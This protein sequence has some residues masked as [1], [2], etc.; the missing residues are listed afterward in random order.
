MSTVAANM[1]IGQRIEPFL[2]YSLES[3]KFLDEYVVVN[4]GNDDNPNLKVVREIIPSAKIVK[5]E[6]DFNFSKARN[7]ALDNTESQWIIWIDADETHFEAFESLVREYSNSHY[8][9]VVF[10]FYHFIL[11]MFH[12][13]SI[14]LRANM[15]RKDGKRWT[16]DVHEKIEPKINVCHDSYRYHHYGYTKPQKEIYENWKL[17]W[18]LNPDERWKCDEP[19]NPNDIISDRVTVAHDYKGEYPEIMR[20]YISKQHT[21]I[22]D[23]KFI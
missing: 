8:D 9:T 19:R 21:L 13:Q 16:G 11:D 3:T 6:G 20:D 2:K 14:D 7:L 15:F 4:T 17:Y 18:S 23:Y 10:G 1:I 5:F 12:Y 22:K